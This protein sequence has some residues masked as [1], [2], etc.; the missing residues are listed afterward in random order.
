M[1]HNI[2]KK[3]LEIMKYK[4]IINT[5][6]C[7]RNELVMKRNGKKQLILFWVYEQWWIIYLGFYL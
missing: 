4:Q 2:S 5:C 7:T 1:K 3:D 6:C